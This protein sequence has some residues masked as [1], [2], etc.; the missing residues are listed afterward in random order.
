MPC[1]GKRLTHITLVASSRNCHGDAGARHKKTPST[2]V[3]GVRQLGRLGLLEPIG[4]CVQCVRKIREF[5]RTPRAPMR[6]DAVVGVACNRIIQCHA[7]MGCVK[8]DAES[9]LMRFHVREIYHCHML[10]SE[11][12][13]WLAPPPRC[14]LVHAVFPLHSRTD[15]GLIMHA[16]K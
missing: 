11:R 10:S 9:I 4:D 14:Y 13:G 1:V 16:E 12:R 6:H 3:D 5:T 15:L 7:S 8:L 2:E